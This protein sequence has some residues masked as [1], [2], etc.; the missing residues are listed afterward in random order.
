MIE[1]TFSVD[2]NP[3]LD[4]RIPV[5]RIEI[6]E[7]KTG[8]VRVK[9]D[10]RDPGLYVEQRGNTIVVASDKEGSFIT[11]ST[12][13]V[14]IETPSG[15]DAYLGAASA[16]IETLVPLGDVEIKS[17]SGDVEVE[18]ADSLR[19]KSASG[20]L[21]V[22]WVKDRLLFTSASGDLK[23]NKSEGSN[24]AASTASGNVRIEESNASLDVNTVSGNLRVNRYEGPRANLKSMSGSM[25]VCIPAGTSIDLDVSLLSG[26]LRLPKPEETKTPVE[27]SMSL[28]AKSVSGDL[29]IKRI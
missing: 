5:G 29:K 26:S 20:N 7:S 1:E 28:R 13:Y 19:V 22:G 3:N 18:E 25:V 4:V 8:Q 24:T 6:R 17:A 11:R 15:S 9:V 12:S 10:T 23:V 16:R 27:R 2:E 14:E 21:R